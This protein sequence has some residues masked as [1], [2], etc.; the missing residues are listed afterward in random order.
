MGG[1]SLCRGECAADKPGMK[2]RAMKEMLPEPLLTRRSEMTP[3]M[4]PNDPN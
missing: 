2:R 1:R 3:E 4:A